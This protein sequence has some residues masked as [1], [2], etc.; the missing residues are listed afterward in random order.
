MHQR[1]IEMFAQTLNHVSVGVLR[2][3]S[4]PTSNKNIIIILSAR[5]LQGWNF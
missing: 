2:Y 1:K 4:L 3:Q 5:L